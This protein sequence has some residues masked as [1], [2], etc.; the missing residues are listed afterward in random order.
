MKK[1]LIR[2][3]LLLSLLILFGCQDSANHE[4]PSVDQRNGKTPIQTQSTN[5]PRFVEPLDEAE[6]Q[7]LTRYEGRFPPSPLDKFKQQSL[8]RASEM[9]YRK[10]KP[11]KLKNAMFP[12]G[13]GNH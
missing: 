13:M 6:P 5:K 9:Q 12:P 7:M 1:N 2:F 8:S 11:G 3:G 4:D 10:A